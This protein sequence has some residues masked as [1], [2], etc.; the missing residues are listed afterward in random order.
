MMQFISSRLVALL[1]ER[2]QL[3]LPIAQSS[4]SV[5]LLLPFDPPASRG[6]IPGRTEGKNQ[7]LAR[8]CAENH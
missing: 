4:L 3:Q 2:R 8:C 7:Q 5:S 6:M 1:Q